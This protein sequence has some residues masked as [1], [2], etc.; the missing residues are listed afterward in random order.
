MIASDE[1]SGVNAAD[2]VRRCAGKKCDKSFQG[3]LPAEW[4]RLA[5]DAG[6]RL[7]EPARPTVL[8]PK[9][10]QAAPAQ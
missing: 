2:V 7:G 4:K 8:C 10:A 6:H 1:L 3:K 9:H 5:P